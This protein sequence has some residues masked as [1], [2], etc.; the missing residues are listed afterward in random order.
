[1]MVVYIGDS[2]LHH[3]CCLTGIVLLRAPVFHEACDKGNCAPK[4]NIESCP[5]LIRSVIGVV[6]T[7]TMLGAYLG[8]DC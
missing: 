7:D 6:Q 3:S 4:M 5:N 2:S 8:N 1:M